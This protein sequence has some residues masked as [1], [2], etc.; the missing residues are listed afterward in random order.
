M[1][2]ARQSAAAERLKDFVRPAGRAGAILQARET[3][4]SSSNLQPP[5]TTE[6]EEPELTLAQLSTQLLAAIHSSTTAL[7]GKIEEVRL[8]V[9][10]LRHDMQNLRERVKETEER[11]SQLEDGAIPVSKSVAE[12]EKVANSWTQRAD[13]LENRLRRNNVRILGLPE[14]AEG[15]DPCAFMETWLK[16]TLPD[17]QIS[18]VFAIERAHRVPAR[19]PPP[20]GTVWRCTLMF[21]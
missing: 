3:E 8:D 16:T 2:K 9:G 12:L 4:S 6:G 18:T 20:D 19:S 21:D 7:T 15:N 1:S 11:I 14:R 13:D 17:A 10:L 5:Q